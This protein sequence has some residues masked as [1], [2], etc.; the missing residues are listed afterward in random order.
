[1]AVPAGAGGRWTDAGWSRER[2]AGVSPTSAGGEVVRDLS[3]VA[4]RASSTCTGVRA[5]EPASATLPGASPVCA[6]VSRRRWR[7]EVSGDRA[8]EESGAQRG[9]T[10]ACR[11]PPT[12]YGR[13]LV[14]GVL[15]V[16]RGR[17]DLSQP[18]G[19][20]RASHTTWWRDR[21][22]RDDVHGLLARL[23]EGN[24]ISFLDAYG[25]E[26]WGQQK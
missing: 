26:N 2:A 4:L 1:M 15:C 16:A 6:G 14:A 20:V 25:L 23:G 3:G 19:P 5:A 13:A 9:R 24:S 18:V 12:A 8:G 10:R 11:R 17:R 21:T 22:Y 7:H